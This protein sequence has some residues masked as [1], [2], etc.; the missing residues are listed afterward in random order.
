MG[1]GL[2]FSFASWSVQQVSVTAGGCSPFARLVHQS[3]D[4][5]KLLFLLSFLRK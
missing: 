2:E 4:M 1:N 5:A 3:I